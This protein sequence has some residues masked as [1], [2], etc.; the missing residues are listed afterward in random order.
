MPPFVGDATEQ[1]AAAAYLAEI[2]GGEPAIGSWVV[3][4]D[5]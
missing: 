2:A 5:E 3:T 4:G 1:R